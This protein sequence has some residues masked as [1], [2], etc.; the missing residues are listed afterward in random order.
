MPFGKLVSV[1]LP[2]SELPPLN[3]HV[4]IGSGAFIGGSRMGSKRDAMQM[5]ALA[6]EK[7]VK[8]WCVLP[9]LF[10]RR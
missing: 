10:D 4:L 8:P 3:P 2:E 9:S 7:G 6:A 1:G 5:L